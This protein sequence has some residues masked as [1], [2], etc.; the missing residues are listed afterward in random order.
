MMQK[1]PS[2]S[3]VV[4]DASNK[5]LSQ[6]EAEVVDSLGGRLTFQQ[7]NFFEPQPVYDANVFLL[8]QCL[9]NYNDLDC[10]KIVRAVVP[11]LEKCD[12]GTPFLINEVILPESGSTTRYVEHHLRQVDMTM[13]VVLGAKQRSERE[14]EKLLKEADPRFEVS[15]HYYSPFPFLPLN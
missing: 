7:H 13:M 11:A 10:I 2:L 8:R 14:F 4:Q 9:H 15:A 1:F 5:M 3:F 12:P 6:A